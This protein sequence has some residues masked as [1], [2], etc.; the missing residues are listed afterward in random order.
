MDDGAGEGVRYRAF[1]SYSHVDKA[2][3]RKLHRRLERYGLPHHLVGRVTARGPVPRRVAPVFRDREEFSAA[4]DLTTEVRAALAASATLIVVCSPAAAASPWVSREV[5]LFR[6]LHPDAPVLAALAEGD[7]AVAFPTPLTI[8]GGAPVEPLAADFRPEGDGPR[9]ALLKLVAGVLGLGLDELIQRDAQQRLRRVTAITA[10]AVAA[11]LAMATLTTFALWQRADAQKQR[12]EAE[13]LVEFMLTDLRDRLK[14]VGRLDVLT[15]VNERTLKY[16]AGQDVERLPAASQMRYARILQ[17]MGEDDMV[18][19][20]TGSALL[21][22]RTAERVTAAGLADSPDDPEWTWAQGQSEYWLGFYSYR[23]EDLPATGKRWRR[24]RELVGRLAQRERESIRYRREL[25]YAEGNLCTLAL[26][27][28]ANLDV[29]LDHCGAAL[30]AMRHV[31]SASPNDRQATD[32]LISRHAWM[33]DVYVA[34][35]DWHAAQLQWKAQEQ[36]L[37][38][39]MGVDPSNTQLRFAWSVLQLGLARAENNLERQDLAIDRLK[40]AVTVM[41]SLVRL[42]PENTR[43]HRMQKNVRSGLEYLEESLRKKKGY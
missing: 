21:K 20:E 31:A 19:G 15:T 3:G 4:G 11:T 36:L 28:Q 17:A 24:Y 14:G 38:S 39:R 43:W 12:A 41:D 13:A 6:E 16:Y 26:R 7:P 1:I 2:F 42:E 10:G 22:F 32:D 23:G 29:A 34:R 5:E 8:A 9:L 18:R 40:K 30:A 25:G 33:A 37:E 27:A 35:N